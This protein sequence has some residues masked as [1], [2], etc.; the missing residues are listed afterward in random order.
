MIRVVVFIIIL[1]VFLGF[2][3][4]NLENKCDISLGFVTLENI[5]VFLSALSS[6]ILGMLVTLPLM[7]IRRKKK[8]KPVAVESSGKLEIPQNQDKINKESSPYGID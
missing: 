7:L 4:L 6:F 2:I 5:P 8:Q 1:A 3:V